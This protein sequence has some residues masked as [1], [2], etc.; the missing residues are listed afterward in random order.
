VGDR[1]SS[2]HAG[3]RR[4]IQHVAKLHLGRCMMLSCGWA[5]TL[6][7]LIAYIIQS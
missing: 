7:L 3:L 6:S 2:H 5:S 1:L 4:M